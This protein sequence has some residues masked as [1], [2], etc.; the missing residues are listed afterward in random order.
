MR[1]L[2]LILEYDGTNFIG[3]QRQKK[4]SSIQGEIERVLEKILH[5]EVRLIS[6]GRTDAGVHAKFQVA[7]F[8]ARSLISAQDIRRAL[9]S[10]LPKDIRIKKA[11]DV[12]EDFHAR[13]CVQSKI[14]K[15]HIYLGEHVSPFISKYVWH[16]PFELNYSVILKEMNCLLGWHDFAKFQAVG[17]RIKNT[18]RCIS[19][20]GFKKSGYFYEFTIEA[21]GFL[22]KMVRLIVGTLIEV[23]RGKFDS[24][25]IA[26]LLRGDDVKRGSVAP[27]QGLF[28]WKVIY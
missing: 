15:Y 14:Y 24:G 9:N 28:L 11:E 2:K 20:V 26:S 18:S 19:N 23:G 3:W 21:N 5:Q 25:R 12:E 1:N 6:S 22:Y 27:P 7:N 17:S 4:G 13:F 10:L 16:V 8:K